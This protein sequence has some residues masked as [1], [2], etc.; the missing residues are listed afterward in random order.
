MVLKGLK[1]YNEKDTYIIYPVRSHG[2]NSEPK[3]NSN[4]AERKVS[5]EV[6]H[7]RLAVNI[8]DKIKEGQTQLDNREH[9]TPLGN[10]MVE[11]FNSL[12]ANSTLKTL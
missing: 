11:E 6:W 1:S 12:L 5:P 4:P 2:Q 10:P 8:E 3:D 9:Y 7:Q